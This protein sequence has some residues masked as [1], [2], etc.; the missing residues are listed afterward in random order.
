MPDESIAVVNSDNFFAEHSITQR[1]GTR[2]LPPYQVMA[3]HLIETPID[4]RLLE[5]LHRK[6]GRRGRL[7]AIGPR[8]HAEPLVYQ[9][10]ENG[11]DA[12]ARPLTEEEAR[13]LSQETRE[14]FNNWK[15]GYYAH[16]TEHWRPWR[17]EFI[18]KD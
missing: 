16:Q 6:L 17:I 5:T 15:N 10:T 3:D 18:K 14:Y 7:Y 8:W 2:D 4:P 9:L 12:H 11:F 1:F 13:S